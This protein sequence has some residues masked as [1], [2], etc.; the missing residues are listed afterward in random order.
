MK[1][2]IIIG[3]LFLVMIFAGCSQAD[4]NKYAAESVKMDGVAGNSMA[5]T[6]SDTANN[7][8]AIERKLIK[9]GNIK[10]ETTDMAAARQTVFNAVTQFKGYVSDD[11]EYRSSS[12]INTYMQVRIPSAQFDS[13]FAAA[14]T[15]VTH[16]DQKNISVNDVTE[17]FLDVET[18]LKT[19]KEL[20]QEFLRLL[21]KAASVK[22][23]LEV[24]KEL[25]AVREQIEIIEGRLAYL[26]NQVG[27][28]TLEIEIYKTIPQSTA[29]GHNFLQAFSNGWQGFIA[30]LLGLISIWPFVLILAGI[31]LFLLP[32][33]K[34]KKKQKKEALAARDEGDSA[35]V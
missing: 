1:E 15:G 5:H 27:F 19:K 3:A 33:I 12:Q 30:F 18:R 29:F 21:K 31:L 20:E 11:R 23:I 2:K 25:N 35:G 4:K 26:Q 32:F 8:P 24:Q 17:A 28:S 14:T 13:F 10:Y 34:R 9:H 22:D 16:F 6:R 7:A